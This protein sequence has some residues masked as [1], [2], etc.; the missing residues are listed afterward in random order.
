M[1]LPELIHKF[2]LT[3]FSLKIFKTEYEYLIR[4]HAIKKYIQNTDDESL[5]EY[6]NDMFYEFGYDRVKIDVAFPRNKLSLI[7]R[8]YLTLHYQSKHSLINSTRQKA[9]CLLTRK[10]SKFI[11]FNPNFGR[12]IVK[13]EK[14]WSKSL[15]KNLFRTVNT[16]NDKHIIFETSQSK[17]TFLNSHLLREE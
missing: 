14:Y 11:N 10:L 2:F 5:F 1:V 9:R 15:C 8:P 16:F 12:K 13:V 3:N 4:E 17:E 7:L 6:A